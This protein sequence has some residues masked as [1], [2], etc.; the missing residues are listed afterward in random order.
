MSSTVRTWI[1][2]AT[3]VLMVVVVVLLLAV[4]VERSRRMARP[5][6][7]EADP[8]MEGEPG[9]P[10]VGVYTGFEYVESVAGKAIFALRSIRTLGKSSGWHE[11]EGVQLQ[12]YDGGVPGPV[13]TAA[14][15]S[16][17]VETRDAELR[18]PIHVTFPTGATITTESGEF[19][20]SSRRFVTD[21][22]V[23]YMH[24]D[25]VVEAGR[26]TYSLPDNRILLT[27]D[28]L[29]TSRGTS[30]RAST[31]EYLRD[32]QTIDLP[33]GCRI[34]QGSAW[35][36]APH[37]RVELAEGDGPPERV[38][39]WGGVTMRHPGGAGSGGLEAWAEKLDAER[40]GQ[41]NWQVDASTTRDWVVVVLRFGST[42]FERTIRTRLLR[43]VVGPDGPINLRAEEGACIDEIPV[44]GEPRRAEAATARVWFKDGEA[45]DMQLDQDVVIWGE[46][47]EARG[48]RA[49]FST[50]AG[51][52]MLHGDPSGLERALVVS[53]RGRVSC[54]QV[55]IHDQDGR[56][57]ARGKVQGMLSDV[58]ILGGEAEGAPAPA[59]FAGDL[60]EI[61]ES[62]GRYRLREGARLWQGHRLLIADDVV[63]RDGDETVE[64]SGHVRATFPAEELGQ[65]EGN[66]GGDDVVV[67]ARS[68]TYDR[69][70]RRAVFRGHVRYSDPG[71]VLSASELDLRFDEGNE[72][73]QV[74]A[75][76]DVELRE[77]AT[78]RVLVAQEAIRDVAA[79]TVYATGSPVR[80]TDVDGTT[81]SSSSLTWNQAD[82]SVTVAGGTE[83]V[84]HPEE[85]L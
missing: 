80:L 24:G 29:L 71:H 62:G 10:A 51:V 47:V 55:Q 63:Y 3:G 16:F 25:T 38:S 52:T 85:E 15:A 17:N 33:Q 2:Y 58:A 68:L 8:S 53:D 66:P 11:I 44:E 6:E 59:H 43:G 69:P 13:V 26:A 20:A 70:G 72:V 30:L 35:V 42:Y 54:D 74:I 34:V 50:A 46:G 18:G 32:E 81:V 40:D 27:D 31:I 12:L 84:Y 56:L 1:R 21:S 36:D 45:T 79:G 67:V 78:S 39:L 19:Q 60:L 75:T 76:G 14:G 28:A 49:R 64:A 41:G 48:H 77:L 4:G 5:V 83:T 22:E 82:G 23:V 61:T 9:D 73:S 7:G 37:A 65:G 57:E